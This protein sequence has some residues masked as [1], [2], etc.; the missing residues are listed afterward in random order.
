MGEVGPRS[1]PGE[2]LQTI[3]SHL[4]PHPDPLLTEEGERAVRA[5]TTS[6]NIR[7]RE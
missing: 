7:I 1:G 3:E 4:A 5:A 2:G 6:A